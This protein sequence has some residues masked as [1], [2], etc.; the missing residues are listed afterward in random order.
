MYKDSDDLADQLSA[1]LA[2]IYKNLLEEEAVPE[3][4]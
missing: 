2:A 4:R 1:P 3:I